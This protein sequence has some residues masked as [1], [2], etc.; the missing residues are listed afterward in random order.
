MTT[1]NGVVELQNRHLKTAFNQALTLC[2]SCDFATAEDCRR[3]FDMVMARRNKQPADGV[4]VARCHLK[5]LPQRRTTDGTKI[6]VPVPRTSGFLV[7]SIVCSAASQLIAQR[8]R[9]HIRDDRVEAFAGG[10]LV[11]T[12][13][14]V[15]GNKGHRVHVI[16]DPHVIPARH[17]KPQAPWRSI[18]RDSLFARLGPLKRKKSCSVTC[19]SEVPAARR[20]KCC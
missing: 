1:E 20:L 2:C 12:H 7:K 16:N 18:R 8:P 17:P 19:R 5:P 10:T 13:S 14:R 3:C 9:A 11:V 6:G 15:R 4:Q